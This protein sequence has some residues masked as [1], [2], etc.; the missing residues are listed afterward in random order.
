M[1]Y[2][3]NVIIKNTGAGRQINRRYKVDSTQRIV[4]KPGARYEIIDDV[5][6][7]TPEDIVFRRSGLDLK[8]YVNH[9]EEPT[10]ILKNFYENSS[11]LL[12]PRPVFTV[13]TFDHTAYLLTSDSAGVADASNAVVYE[14]FAE[15]EVQAAV[16]P[17]AAGISPLWGVAA[18]GL[19]AGAAAAAGGGGGGSGAAATVAKSPSGQTGGLAHTASSDTGISSTDSIT[20]NTTPVIAGTGTAGDT[21]S[22]S[23]GNKTYTT[24]VDSTGHYSVTI[25]TGLKD[26]T[27]IP[28]ITEIDA[29]GNSSTVN[30]TSF[31]V[32]TTAPTAPTLTVVGTAGVA[33]PATSGT[34]EANS[35]VYI[36]DNGSTTPI[37]SA[38]TNAAGVWTLTPSVTLPVGVDTLTAIAVDT[39]SNTSAVSSATYTVNAPTPVETVAITSMTQDS[40]LSSTD[41]ITNDGSAG[42]TVSGTLSATLAK[43]ETV[44]VFIGSLDLGTATVNG[45]TWTITDPNNHNASW[46]YTAEVLNSTGQASL[47]APQVVTLDTAPPDLSTLLGH[48]DHSATSDTGTSS[49][50]SITSNG[51]PVFV[52]V[53]EANASVAVTINGITYK[54]T[55]SPTTASTPGAY[56]VELKNNGVPLDGT[57]TAIITETDLAGNTA[58][59]N[60]ATANNIA[61]VVDH[62]IPTEVVTFTS[63][64]KDSGINVTTSAEDF[65]TNDSSAGRLV[66]GTLSASLQAG[67]VL[68][69]YQN[70]N[71]IGAAATSGTDWIITDNTA[72]TSSA[73]WTYT[74]QVVNVVGTGGTAASQTVNGV[75]TQNAPR[76]TDVIDSTQQH[77]F[78][79]GV[80]ASYVA[81]VIGT[82]TAG[83]IV[84]LYDSVGTNCVGTAT[85]GSSGTWTIA[86]SATGNYNGDN[87]FAADQFSDLGNLSALSGSVVITENGPPSGSANSPTPSLTSGAYVS[88]AT[89]GKDALTYVGSGA[90]DALAGDD[91]ISVSAGIE[92]QLLV[93]GNHINGGTGE[94]TLSISTGAN[95][96]LENL[97]HGTDTIQALE[98]IQVVTLQ[99]NSKLTLSANDVLALGTVGATAYSFGAT[100]ASG[101][102]LAG[103]STSS[104]GKVQ[105]IINGTSNDNVILDGIQ[106]H[107]S[108]AAIVGTWVDEGQVTLNGHTYEVFNHNTTNAQ[109]LIDQAIHLTHS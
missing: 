6:G 67:E 1:E 26:N 12:G 105:E 43:G 75:Y 49:L 80:T 50:D 30:G 103:A 96:N 58:T 54:T 11:S 51:N 66:A 79:G 73:Q 87:I 38:T 76:I 16:L 70:G 101:T 109:V 3:Q 61:F 72:Y 102:S 107:G 88:G 46:T 20:S 36:Y 37:G 29:A 108:S 32:D 53:A 21:I 59:V 64:G 5:T 104:A 84:Y 7:K 82:G 97:D 22:V 57:Y 85:V 77:V 93:A 25:T 99:G 39:A 86:V 60:T 83:D 94:N 19:A 4:A 52:G 100:S 13:D 47:F 14:T 106:H 34:S 81:N 89:A 55:A 23:V 9:S 41:F 71:L 44:H 10:L 91:V 33:S 35:I 45:T 98:Q 28:V 15:S 17:L 31:V 18:G 48:L 95:L 42:R 63:M 74:A 65:S 68:N 8:V 62:S 2:T 69:V 92:N 90:L 24:T 78:S 40:G 56:S 27:Y